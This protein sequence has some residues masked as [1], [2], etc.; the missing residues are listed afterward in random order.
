MGNFTH[1][2]KSIAR[3]Y[4]QNFWD[5][6]KMRITHQLLGTTPTI[7]KTDPNKLLELRQG[8][9]ITID[10]VSLY[11]FTWKAPKHIPKHLLYF[12][13]DVDILVITIQ[14]LTDHDKWLSLLSAAIDK[15]QYIKVDGQYK[16]GLLLH[17]Y[18]RKSLKSRVSNVQ[19]ST[20]K[21]R[22]YYN[23]FISNKS[24]NL[25]RMQLDSTKMVFI[26]CQL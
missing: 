10:T 19:M 12:P 2:Y 4:N 9:F 8:E 17:V 20:I 13:T 5:F 15:E 7:T 21:F 18:I 26:G 11:I 22:S 25:L 24:A 1:K 6:F 14:D 3:F 16:N 23:T